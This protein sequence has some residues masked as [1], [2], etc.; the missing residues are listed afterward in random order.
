MST[1]FSGYVL[2]NT[3]KFE[4][5]EVIEICCNYNSFITFNKKLKNCEY[6]IMMFH[7]SYIIVSNNINALRQC[8]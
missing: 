7:S 1:S 2:T 5:I 4:R 3:Y 8:H 6:K